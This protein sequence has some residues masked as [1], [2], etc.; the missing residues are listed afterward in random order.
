[1]IGGTGGVASVDGNN[2]YLKF[3]GE[4]VFQVQR[5]YVRSGHFLCLGAPVYA[6]LVAPAH[7]EAISAR[8]PD[9]EHSMLQSVPAVAEDIGTAIWEPVRIAMGSL[10]DANQLEKG[11]SK[12]NGTQHTRE[13]IIENEQTEK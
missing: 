13:Q 11:K 10:V 2:V 4:E 7:V 12:T 1:M 5:G 8:P 6:P 3:D 9:G